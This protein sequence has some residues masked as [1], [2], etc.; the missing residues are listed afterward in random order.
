MDVPHMIHEGPPTFTQWHDDE[1]HNDHNNN[2]R[3]P[4]HSIQR[5]IP[6]LPDTGGGCVSTIARCVSIYF[7]NEH[8]KAAEIS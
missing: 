2:K 4:N 5:A 3:I 8:T 1:Q 7:I 6:T